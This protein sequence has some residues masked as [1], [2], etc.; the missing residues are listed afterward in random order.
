MTR[1]AGEARFIAVEDAARYRDALGAPLPAGLPLSLLEPV[2]AAL[3]SLLRRWARTHVPFTAEDP[4]RR[5]AVPLAEVD[6]SLQR[7]VGRG[8]A[9]HSA[10]V[11]GRASARGGTG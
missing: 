3:D 9:Y 10:P 11:A 7:L 8:A 5:W 4:A 6:H 1:I 2:E